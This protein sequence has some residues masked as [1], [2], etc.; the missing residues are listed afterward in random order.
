MKF[1]GEFLTP[2]QIPQAVGYRIVVAPIKIEAQTSGGIIL[3]SDVKKLEET[4]RF[5]VKVLSVG[6]VAF[7]HDKFKP[8]T[9][10]EPIA[11]CKV[12]DIISIGSYAGSEV[13][14]ISPDNTPFKLKVIN[15]DEVDTLITDAGALNV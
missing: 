13:P 1:E 9:N 12:G 4:S 15:D 7:K 2:E 10:A 8:H 3:P 5:I 11:S 14:M 6:P